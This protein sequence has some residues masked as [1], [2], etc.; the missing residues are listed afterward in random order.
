MTTVEKIETPTVGGL[1]I[2]GWEIS[3][4]HLPILSN[5]EIEQY[6]QA[7]GFNV[8]EMIF[9]NNYLR[10]T[11]QATGKAIELRALDALRMVDV[12]EHSAKSVQVSIAGNWSQAQKRKDI[13]DV[14]KPFDWTYTTRYT[15]TPAGGLA[16]HASDAG[17][18]YDR[19]KVRE[20]ILFF[21]E[22][23]LYE[24]DL[25]DNGTSQ[26]AYKVRVMASGFFFGSDTVLRETSERECRAKKHDDEDL[27]M[28]AARV[29]CAAARLR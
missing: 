25:G 2:H 14:I 4:C 5:K 9:G 19:L 13:T 16:F 27:A 29:Q 6:S 3:S 10:L 7:L 12:S 22:N 15:G 23:V 11:H 8:P 28:P 1:R 26:L 24:D 17:I 20:D 21:D 18:D